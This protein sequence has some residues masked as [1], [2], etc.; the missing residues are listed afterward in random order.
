MPGNDRAST[1]SFSDPNWRQ[2]ARGPLDAL[3]ITPN[4]L[5]FNASTNA[6][7]LIVRQSG[8]W[9]EYALGQAGLDYVH[10]A[11]REGR[12]REGITVQVQ[13]DGIVGTIKSVTKMVAD[14]NGRPPRDG[15]FG[16]YW[17]INADG[18]PN[19]P[20]SS[21]GSQPPLSEIPF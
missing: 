19:A 1:F 17:W 3:R 13:R 18:T 12:I 5:W 2:V 8:Q 15:P 7:A 6:G 20:Y 14:L 11:E 21:P 16:P 10:N 4:E 9:P